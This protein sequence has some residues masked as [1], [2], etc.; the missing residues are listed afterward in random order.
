M[1]EGGCDGGVV[2]YAQLIKGALDRRGA[3]RNEELTDA[4]NHL[5][6]TAKELRIPLMVLSQIRRSDPSKPDRRPRSSDLKDCGAFEQDADIVGLLHRA[7][8]QDDGPTEFIID[9]MRNGATGSYVLTLVGD[10]VT[11]ID[12][13][14]MPA[15][16]PRAEPKGKKIAG[17]VRP[18]AL[19]MGREAEED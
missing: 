4:S 16:A 17:K 12:G 2:D 9:K 15:P 19:P 10:V 18:P 7:K 14:V 11:F 3:S 13:G 5:K 1:A 6:E 8:H